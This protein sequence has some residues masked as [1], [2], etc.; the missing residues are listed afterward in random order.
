MGLSLLLERDT[1]V[2]TC[3]ELF[4]FLRRKGFS[5]SISKVFDAY[6]ALALIVLG[7]RGKGQEALALTLRG[8][9]LARRAWLHVDD[10]AAGVVALLR[11]GQ[12]GEVHHF[13]GGNERT[14]AQLAAQVAELCGG[15][16]LV[17]L[18]ERPG[19]DRRYIVLELRV[20]SRA[21]AATLRAA[22][23]GRCL[24]LGQDR[25]QGPEVGTERAPPL[26][27]APP[28]APANS[29]L[30]Q[31]QAQQEALR[32]LGL[33]RHALKRPNSSPP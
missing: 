18:P 3:G 12:P 24:V 26:N 8:A 5:F 23:D 15:G 4:W 16:S 32:L 13:A 9:G 6:R 33:T 17:Y 29:V 1:V 14:N 7:D 25:P 10:F 28:W 31:E 2:R 22:D 30:L 19:Q 21:Q 27:R 11:R 20:P